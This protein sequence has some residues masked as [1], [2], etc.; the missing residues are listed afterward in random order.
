MA[1]LSV[2]ELFFK[3]RVCFSLKCL[4]NSAANFSPHK[5]TQALERGYFCLARKRFRA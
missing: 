1:V 3:E 5:R 4:N 2:K